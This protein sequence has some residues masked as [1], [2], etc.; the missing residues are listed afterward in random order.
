MIWPF[1][2]FGVIQIIRDSFSP[3]F[4]AFPLLKLLKLVKKTFFEKEKQKIIS[5]F[6]FKGLPS[7]ILWNSAFLRPCYFQWFSHFY[8][9]L[10]W[11]LAFFD[12]A[13]LFFSITISHL[14]CTFKF[15]PFNY[16]HRFKIKTVDQYFYSE[17]IKVRNHLNRM[18]GTFCKWMNGILVKFS[19]SQKEITLKEN[20]D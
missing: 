3:I 4:R 13:T 18:T 11:N 16:S 15:K 12:L 5:S 7:T 14:K 10:W 2:V 17:I 9:C 19:S 20:F 6:S 1:L 8:N